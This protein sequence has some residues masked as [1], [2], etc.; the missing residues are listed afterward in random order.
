[1]SSKIKEVLKNLLLSFMSYA[2][3][4]AILQFVIQPMLAAQ[5]GAEANGQYLTL[6]SLN[7]FI[8]GVT[9]GVLNTVRMLKHQ[10]YEDQGL[11][12]DFN[13]FMLIYAALVTVVLV[14]GHIFYLKT[15]DAADM[16]LY[17]V[18]GLLYLY[19][20]YIFCQYRLKF[21]Y[22]K[23]LINNVI[24][25]IGYFAGYFLFGV[26]GRWQVVIIGAYLF[27]GV[28]DFFNTDFIREP[29]RITPLFKGTRAKVLALTLSTALGSA[30]VYCDKL[31]LYPLLGGTQVS[32]Y[33]TAS[34][35]GKMLV[36]ISSPLNS[37]FLSY[38]VKMDKLRLRLN[39]KMLLIILCGGIAAYGA[40]LLVGYPMVN[41]LYPDWASQS[42]AYI[43]LTVLASLLTFGAGILNT[44]VIRFCKTYLQVIIQG[45]ELFLY[46]LLS[47][48]LLHF[49][50]LMGFCIGV[51][52]TAAIKM[53]IVI[54]VIT[55]QMKMEEKQ[56]EPV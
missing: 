36:L 49:F 19:H 16:L 4:T 56:N 39:K 33:S 31:L 37:V 12:G 40:C 7:Y 55:K 24:Q 1:M 34:L 46:L 13:V 42:H 17:V 50:G 21:Q 48:L 22:N 47:L 6:M 53:V 52:I 23:I 38:L 28:Y 20:N 27:S 44:V 25:V 41:L 11:K 35:V 45:T 43:P 3:P 32:I 26:V 15:I 8:V 2:L 29:V 30:I 51:V 10:E 14:A 9:G 5:L 54:I 18:V